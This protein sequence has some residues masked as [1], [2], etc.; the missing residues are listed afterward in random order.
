[1]T[2]QYVNNLANPTLDSCT[3]AATAAAA[4]D[5]AADATINTAGHRPRQGGALRLNCYRSE[6]YRY[7]QIHPALDQL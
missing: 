5:D 6:K 1:M 3:S 4:A 7:I 2:L